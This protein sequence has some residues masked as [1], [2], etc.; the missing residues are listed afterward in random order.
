MFEVVG[1]NG[2]YHAILH[3]VITIETSFRD[4]YECEVE[5]CECTM[6]VIASK[7]LVVI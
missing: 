6:K 1:F 5:N 3:N 2:S 7:K 4:A